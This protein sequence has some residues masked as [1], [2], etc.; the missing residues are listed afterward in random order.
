VRAAA[1]PVDRSSLSRAAVNEVHP[2]TGAGAAPAD[3]LAATAVAYATFVAQRRVGFEFIFADELT[4]LDCDE[5]TDAGQAVIDVLLPLTLAMRSSRRRVRG[6]S[7]RR[8]R[9][10]DLAGW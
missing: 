4:R 9:R 5:L 10:V 6:P 2:R 7:A 1:V 3:A 8:W